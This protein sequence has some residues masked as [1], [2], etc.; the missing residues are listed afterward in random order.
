[1]S[2]NEERRMN[3]IKLQAKIGKT[4]KYVVAQQLGGCRKR[5]IFGVTWRS[6]V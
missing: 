3:K 5:E 1:M 6:I 2:R 4:Y